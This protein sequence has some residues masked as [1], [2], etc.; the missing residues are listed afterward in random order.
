MKTEWT[1][2]QRAHLALRITLGVN[3]AGHGLVR[4]GHARAFAE[5]MAR[6]FGATM[7][8]GWVAYAFLLALP[9]IELALGLSMLIG[10][11]LRVTLMA[12]AL[13][14]AALTFGS[15]MKQAWDAAGLQLV[16]ALAY[17]VLLSRA[18]DARLCLGGRA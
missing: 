15:C 13:L 14:M 8:P 5:G 9:F 18:A 10:F 1:D 2:G 12:G 7:L 17:Y 16:Y 6:D 3:I 11:R 4:V